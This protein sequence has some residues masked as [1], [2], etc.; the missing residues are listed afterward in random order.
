MPP[1]TH[2]HR[3]SSSGFKTVEAGSFGPI[4]A[5]WT[6][7]RLLYLATVL[8]LSRTA[9]PERSGS[10]DYIVSLE[11]HRLGRAGASMQYLSHNSSFR[12]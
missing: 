8:V 5:S 3:A 4:G 7:S 12:G 10:L 2:T 1:E 9:S 11:T 6:K